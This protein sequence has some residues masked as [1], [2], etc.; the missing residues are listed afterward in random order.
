MILKKAVFLAF[1]SVIFALPVVA[2]AE[3][4][5][6]AIKQ[7]TECVVQ[8][9]NSL[10]RIARQSY[11]YGNGSFLDLAMLIAEKNN[12][13]GPR[14]IIRPG[15]RLIIPALRPPAKAEAVPSGASKTIVPNAHPAEPTLSGDVDEKPEG[16]SVSGSAEVPAKPGHMTVSHPRYIEKWMFITGYCPCEICTK[17][18][19]GHPY[20][21]VTSTGDDARVLDGVAAAYTL[22]PEL[23]E[24]TKVIIPGI[25]MREVDD[26]GGAMR[27]NARRGIYHLDVRYANHEEAFKATRWAWVKILTN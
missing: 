19:P 17:K 25:G 2:V 10:S 9:G 24:R 23:R 1:M 21:G 6:S 5:Q 26:T 3:T 22:L 13:S 14:Y 15:Q 20:Y 11:G 7:E 12:I 27:Q 18:Q 4:C 16:E 8:P